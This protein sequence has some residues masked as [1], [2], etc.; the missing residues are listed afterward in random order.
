VSLKVIQG[1]FL[2]VVFCYFV[3]FRVAKIVLFCVGKI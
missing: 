2:Y 1:E 3:L